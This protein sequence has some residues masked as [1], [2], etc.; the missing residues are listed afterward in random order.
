MTSSTETEAPVWVSVGRIGRPH[1]VKGGT[2]LW[3]HNPDSE[4][5][6]A[7]LVITV[8]PAEMSADDAN[9]ASA[10][11]LTIADVY[12]EGLVTFVGVKHREDVARFTG[13]TVYVNREDFPDVDDDETYLVDLIGAKVQSATDEDKVYGTITGFDDNGAQP[14]ALVDTPNGEVVMPFAPGLVVDI[15]DDH[16]VVVVDAPIG[17]FEGDAVEARDKGNQSKS[18]RDRARARRRKKEEKR[19]ASRAATAAKE[20]S[21]KAADVDDEADA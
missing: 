10:R 19:R 12:G 5:L 2:R 20:A 17:L 11:Q 6:Q 3:L 21:D 14:L 1:G 16:Q 15:S 8:L 13:R 18:E 9:G 7:D 4:L